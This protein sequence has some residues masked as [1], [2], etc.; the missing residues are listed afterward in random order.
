MFEL[1]FRDYLRHNEEACKTY[2]KLKIDLSKDHNY[3]FNT[4]AAV[5]PKIKLILL[6]RATASQRSG[7]QY[8]VIDLDQ[9]PTLSWLDVSDL[10]KPRP[11]VKQKICA[12]IRKEVTLPLFDV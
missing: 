11:S 9:D 1:T 2:A 4:V 12:P 7:C 10:L 5:I 3:A 8:H 6:K